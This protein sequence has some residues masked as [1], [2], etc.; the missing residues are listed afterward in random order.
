MAL[1]ALPFTVLGVATYR[2]MS[3]VDFK[4]ATHGL[5]SVSGSGLIFK[6]FASILSMLLKA[7]FLT[8]AAL[9]YFGVY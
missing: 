1:M 2:K 7:K 3:D 9:A 8:I 6:G 4:K 5:M